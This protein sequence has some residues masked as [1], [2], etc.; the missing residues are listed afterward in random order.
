M[1]SILNQSMHDFEHIAVDDFSTDQP[2][3]ILRSYNDE[4]IR[5]IENE[6]KAIV[7]ALNTG[8]TVYPSDYVARMDADEV[9]YAQLVDKQRKALHED[10]SITTLFE[11][12]NFQA[13]S[14]HSTK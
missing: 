14:S 3:D 2:I 13:Y 6:Y 10:S 7:S 9:M 8:L 4:R 5:A 1:D 11:L 12:K